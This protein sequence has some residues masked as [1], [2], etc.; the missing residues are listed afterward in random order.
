M[1]LLEEVVRQF[2][3]SRVAPSRVTTKRPRYAWSDTEVPGR[4][5]RASRLR[6]RRKA[7]RHKHEQ[8]FFSGERGWGEK[9]S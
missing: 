5:Q 4:C 8:N 9:S 2:L 3:G 6:T 7:S 1:D